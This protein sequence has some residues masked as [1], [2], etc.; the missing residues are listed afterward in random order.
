MQ[1]MDA[2]ILSTAL[3]AIARDF[4]ANPI[5]L[6]LAV[7]TYLLALA[8]FIPASSWVADRFGPRKVFR[9]AIAVFALGSI[10]CALSDGLVSLVL[11]RALQGIGGAMMVPVGRIVVLRAIPKSELVGAMAWLTIPALTGPVI[12]PPL[13]GFITTYFN[14]RYIFWINVPI[15]VLGIWLVTRFIPKNEPKHPGPFDT[16]GF[17]L[18]GPGLAAFLTGATVA[19]LGLMDTVTNVTVTITGA[20]LIALYVRHA[21]KVQLPI[22]DL[23][24][25]SITTF[26]ASVVGGMLF[27][28]GIGAFPFL[29]PLLFQ[30][31]FNMTPF[32]SGMLTFASGA[33][34]I[35]MKL[36]APGILR[37]FG[38]RNVLVINAW[39]A[40]LFIAMP[41][42]FTASTP[43]FLI[44]ILLLLGGFSRS[45][46][47]T[48]INSI[49]YADISADKLSRAAGFVAVLQELSGTIGVA[50]AALALE[51]LQTLD[52]SPTIT[53]SHFPLVFA[54]IALL[55]AASSIIF[56]RLS[57]DAGSSMLVKGNARSENLQESASQ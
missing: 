45:L 25:L 44:I 48:S 15:A 41:G 57:K 12:G 50:V 7:T 8:V 6:K 46:Q 14:W 5:H 29:L 55:S 22:I 24:L 43:W 4:D 11:S 13:G 28:V 52:G 37:Q 49:A 2:T 40:A 27:R 30:L 35:L 34:A 53:A 32:E 16:K 1:T 38:Y 51:T 33:G 23:K 19:G 42:W 9:A 36:A 10:F 3:P 54:G 47:F 39:L 26:R 56:A 17:L 18:L 31:G 21:L 20:V